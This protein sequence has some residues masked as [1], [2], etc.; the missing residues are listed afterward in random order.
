MAWAVQG[1]IRGPQGIQGIQ[2]PQG[3]TGA[4]GTG[5]A[6]A[7]TVA[8]YGDLPSGLGAG[9]AGNG[10]L[11]T[12]DGL[13]YIWD[14]AQF[15]AD[16]AGVQFKGPKGDTGATG[17]AAT[18]AFGTT[19]TGAAGSSATVSEDA[20]STPQ[21]RIYNITVPRGA[22]GA[23]GDPGTNGTNGAR[24]FTGSGAPGVVAGASAGDFYLDVDDG[25]L[26]ELS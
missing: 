10:Y 25:T 16:G 24:W 21:A 23:T 2:G 20:A 11:V 15:P 18:F 13:L 4:D 19:S 5:I 17:S 26:Y 3:P 1:N 14:G 8:T 9:D 7:G 6:I 12:A 22:T